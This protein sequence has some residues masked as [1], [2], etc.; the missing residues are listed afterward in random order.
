VSD[1]GLDLLDFRLALGSV[2]LGLGLRLGFQTAHLGPGLRL[3]LPDFSAR[4]G[5]DKLRLAHALGGF[6]E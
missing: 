3:N 5:F 4:A 1:L 2:A 6:T